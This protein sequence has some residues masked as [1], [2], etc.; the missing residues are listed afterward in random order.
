MPGYFLDLDFLDF[1]FDLDRRFLRRVRLLVL[2]P[3]NEGTR[4]ALEGPGTRSGFCAGG[5]AGGGTEAVDED[6]NKFP[7]VSPMSNSF[8]N[9]DLTESTPL[10]MV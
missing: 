3:T 1:L 10:L 4:G 6:E 5:G 7:I 8:V 2:P 9:A